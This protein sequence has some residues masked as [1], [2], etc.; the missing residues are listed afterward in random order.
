VTD[1]NLLLGYLSRD[2][3]YGNELRLDL[4]AAR[5]AVGR[6]AAEAGIDLFD[7]ALGVVRV[8]NHAMMRALR[9][10]TVER[11]VD[12]RQCALIAFGGAGPMH[13]VAVARA[14]GIAQVIVPAQSSVFSATGCVHAQMGYAQQQTLRVPAERWDA[15]LINGVRERLQ[16]RLAAPLVAAGHR[17]EML[18]VE[19]TASVRY[20]GQSYAIELLAPDFADP[21]RLGRDFLAE[22][23]RLY[24]FATDEPWELVAIRLRVAAPRADFAA[25][26]VGPA[27]DM[28]A[29][30]GVSPCVF[31]RS[32]ERTTPRFDRG[33]LTPGKATHGPAVIEDAFSTVVVPPGA[34]LTPDARGH[35]F[36]SVGEASQAARGEA[37]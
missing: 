3:L 18:A 16:A 32:G 13:A 9:R 21:G 36:I 15:E 28:G 11:G 1:A 37:A 6:L 24:G 7:A 12:G 34:T 25:A 27:A 14:Y 8:A 4:D 35:L 22:H 20:R 19:A 5:A 17:T 33:A 29:P 2:R 26:A 31:D 30:L 10:V 23:E